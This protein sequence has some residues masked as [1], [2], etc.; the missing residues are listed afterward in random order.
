[1]LKHSPTKK[2]S[3][4]ILFYSENERK[5]LMDKL[6]LSFNY[7]FKGVYFSLLKIFDGVTC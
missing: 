1:M 3:F 2:L 4:V 6:Q 5:E 7:E